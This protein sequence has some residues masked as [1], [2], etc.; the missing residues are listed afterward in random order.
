MTERTDGGRQAG[1]E[2]VLDGVRKE[3]GSFVAVDDISLTIKSGE[4]MTLLGP[5]G[6]GKTTLLNMI[7]GFTHPDR[8]S[9]SFDGKAMGNIAPYRRGI[10]VVLQNYALFPHMTVA[11]NVEFPL[12]MRRERGAA[13]RERALETLALV[14]MEQHAHK[15]P[16]Q[17]SGGQQQRVALARALVFDPRIILM[18]E[19]LSALDRRLRD[20]LQMEIRELHSTLGAT[21]VYVT[22]DQGEALTMSDRI[23]VMDGGKILALT[24]PQTMYDKPPATFVASFLGESNDVPATLVARDGDTGSAKFGDSEHAI[25]LEGVEAEVGDDIILTIRPERVLLSEPGKPGVAGTVARVTF[26]GEM[27]RYDVELDGSTTSVQARNPND[28]TST[29]WAPGDAVSVHWNPAKVGA[30]R[31]A[32][33]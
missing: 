20:R 24:E 7:A 14:G 6:S 8:G 29:V 19:P 12:R 30:V 18:D 3:F 17:L 2:I 11:A 10:G 33:A 15:S 26:L 5:S 16:T 23:T 4:F 21:I 9:I 13:A 25:H 32:N 22:H 1:A 31:L 27:Y 28:G